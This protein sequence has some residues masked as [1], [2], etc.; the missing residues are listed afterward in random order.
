VKTVQGVG[1]TGWSRRSWAAF[2]SLCLVV[3][4]AF[5]VLVSLVFHPHAA[6]SALRST[7]A[8]VGAPLARQPAPPFTLTDQYGSEISLAAQKGRVVLLAFMDPLCVEL[9][10]V[11]G[12][13]IVAVEQKLPKGINPELIIVSVTAG[14][15][16]ADVQHFVTTNLS[17][18]W[19]PGW[20]W[21]IGP[22]DAA[23]KLT[24][25]HWNVPITPPHD[26]VL[27]IIDPQGYLRV[28]YPAPLFVDDTVAAITKVAHG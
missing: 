15:T 25:L 22:N 6:V 3:G 11:L 17:T 19:L 23:L 26:N 2:V 24:W 14:R 16:S 4:L 21:L 27:D 5:G 8:V 20:H 13:D 18:Q 10:P 9:C 1:V 28:T 7:N 12:R